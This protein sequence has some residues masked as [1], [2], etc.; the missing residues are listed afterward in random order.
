MNVLCLVV[1][2]VC[3]GLVGV[4]LSGREAEGGLMDAWLVG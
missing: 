4:H 1:C 2:G 3:V